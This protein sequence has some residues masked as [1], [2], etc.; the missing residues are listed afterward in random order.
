MIEIDLSGKVAIVTGAR[1]GLG[2]QIALILARAGANI[3]ANSRSF[4]DGG[5]ELLD[6]INACGGPKAIIAEGTVRE[7]E[8]I[9]KVVEKALTEFEQIDILVNNAGIIERKP[10]I[11]IDDKDWESILSV[12]LSG[13]FKISQAVVKVMIKQGNGRIVNIGSIAGKRGSAFYA[14]YAASKGALINLTK[15]LARELGKYGILVN[16]I[17]PGRIKTD[18]LMKTMNTEESRW[19]KE[20][21][22][23]RLG[24]PEEIAGA[25]LFLVSDLANYITGETIEVNGGVLM[26]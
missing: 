14:H 7:R 10:F 12:N 3:V 24:T 21:P 26:D 25:V 19:L 18:L 9:E 4:A 15:T 13:A 5:K 6:E 22:L 1:R 17:N 8:D 11:E 20:T 23:R 16:A 2:R